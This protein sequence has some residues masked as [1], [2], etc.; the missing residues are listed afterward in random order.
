MNIVHHALDV[1]APIETV[2]A[3]ITTSDGL[4]S[5]WTRDVQAGTAEVGSLFRFS[6]RGVFNPHLRITEI[7]APL[8]VTFEGVDSHDAWG[9]TTIRFV[10]ESINGATLVRFWHHMGPERSSDGVASANFT[11]AYYLNSLRLL[12]ERG[13]GAPYQ[14]GSSKAR[15]GAASFE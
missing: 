2:F 11:W 9:E 5:W 10:L 6:F 1:R 4:A 15:V 14:P 3:A 12:C 8:R 7:E 13:E